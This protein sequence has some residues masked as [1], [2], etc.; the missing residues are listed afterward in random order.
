MQTAWI[1]SRGLRPAVVRGVV[2]L[3]AVGPVHAGG[4]STGLIPLSELGT[5]TYQGFPGGLYPGAV[6]DPPP[7][8]A[9]AAAAAAGAIVPRDAAGAP[10]PSGFIGCIAIGMS[11]TFHEFSVFERQEDANTT[12]NA[13]V[14]I[15][16]TAHPGQTASTIANSAAMYWTIVSDRIAAAGL[17][18]AQ[19]QVAWMKEANGF[20]QNNFPVHAQQLRDNLRTIVQILHDRFP[21]LRI[22]YLSSRIYGGYATG[23]LNPEPMAYE[24][25]FSVRWLIEQQIGGDA[26]LNYDA[27]RG[28]VRAPLLL[29]GPYLW[30]D[31][32]IP[33]S[34]GLTWL[35]GD[36]ESD[37][38]HPSASG[39]QK[40]GDQL[41]AYFADAPSAA[42]WWPAQ[43]GTRLVPLA[44]TA[45]SF[46]SAGFPN[47]ND[48]A[49]VQLR[50]QG[51]TSPRNAYVKFNLAGVRRP[52]LFAKLSLRCLAD[53]GGDVHLVDDTTWGELTIT[54]NNAPPIGPRLVT[55]PQAPSDGTIAVDA[56]AAV[57]ADEDGV[58]SFANVF[59]VASPLVYHSREAGQPPRL[60]LVV[61]TRL[62]GDM[63]C[64]GMVDNFDLDPFVLALASPGDYAGQFPGCDRLNGDMNDDGRVNNFDIDG[65]VAALT[66]P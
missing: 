4:P 66:R 15:L 30:A 55:L 27:A 48:G 56:T 22:C 49:S 34:D 20:P 18:P 6:N 8:H 3:L 13:R 25:G 61:S 5:A 63:N 28:A 60:V 29:W 46:V 26:A 47:S 12:R 45:D 65:F 62:A 52:A 37:G 1:A 54:Y 57:N 14:V 2:A 33:R 39:E 58:L 43:P 59:P 42:L 41:S 31:G 44:A 11:N 9:A 16:N 7:A 19:V 53:G 35:A 50:V 36:F 40:V 17:T 38:T 21:N 23:P 64:D 51:G 24:S 10:D 32:V